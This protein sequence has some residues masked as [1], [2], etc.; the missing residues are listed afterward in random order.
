MS[1]EESLKSISLDADDTIGIY[2]GVPG[3]PGSADPN[4]GM[5]YHFL[6]ITGPHQV[7][8]YAG[9]KCIGVLQNKPQKPGAASTVGFHG[10]SNVMVG[11]G[12]VI[13]AGDLIA[14]DPATGLA[15]VGA[16]DTAVGVAIYGADGATEGVIIP[17]LLTLAS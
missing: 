1:Y 15:I 4:Y 16:P 8:L 17:V 7:G 11:Q 6:E 14:A 10:V 5:Q 13:A 12:T 2:T 9:G 3:L